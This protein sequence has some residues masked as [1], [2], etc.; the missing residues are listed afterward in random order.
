MKGWQGRVEQAGGGLPRGEVLVSEP[1]GV[2][3]V[4][5]TVTALAST[6]SPSLPPLSLPLSSAASCSAA[7]VL[8]TKTSLPLIKP[9]QT[10]VK[11]PFSSPL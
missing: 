7:A 11:T 1:S 5:M 10:V 6:H 9:V 2:E 3:G 8:C 4:R